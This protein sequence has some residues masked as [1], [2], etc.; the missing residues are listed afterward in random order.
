MRV[1]EL[2]LKDGGDKIFVNPEKIVS[3]KSFHHLGENWQW[4]VLN[5]ENERI[6]V[7]ENA[8]EILLSICIVNDGKFALSGETIEKYRKTAP[9]RYW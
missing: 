5:L 2:H 8:E 3:F 6:N 1:V 9:S 4:S 7:K